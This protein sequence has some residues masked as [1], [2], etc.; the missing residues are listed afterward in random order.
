MKVY[1]SELSVQ[2]RSR[3]DL[4]DI[5]RQVE[6]AVS[7][8]QIRNG[9]CLVYAPHATAAII[10][11]EHESGLLHD[12]L[13]KVRDLFPEGAGYRH[14]RIDDNAHAHLA[15]AFIASSRIFPVR[16][17]TLIRGTWQN[18]MLVEADGPR[19]RRVV[20]EVLGE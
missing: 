15:S 8:S 16:D 2:T 6:A 19:Y 17:G 1:F 11:N 20:V 14:D 18:I 3:F 10:A 12:L 9:L 13:A 5:T 7:A 4:V